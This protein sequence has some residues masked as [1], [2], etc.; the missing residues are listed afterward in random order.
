MGGQ[1]AGTKQNGKGTGARARL[2][3]HRAPVDKIQGLSGERFLCSLAF[4]LDVFVM[5]LV[6]Y[7]T[8]T[9]SPQQT[10]EIHT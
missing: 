1:P 7:L 4:Y 3:G 6:K 9:Q 2:D 10:K 5:I 8:F